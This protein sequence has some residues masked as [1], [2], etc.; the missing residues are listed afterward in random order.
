MRSLHQ[1]MALREA[2][3]LPAHCVIHSLRHTALTRLGE[4]G[5]GAFEIMRIAGHSTV[6]VSQ[7]YVHPSP[8]SIERAFERLE[9]MNTQ[10]RAGLP[11]KPQHGHLL[12][13]VLTTGEGGEVDAPQEVV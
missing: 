1:H 13:T 8:E 5:A 6:T 2:M 12:P 11:A 3:R 10:A 7:K 9:A 4:S